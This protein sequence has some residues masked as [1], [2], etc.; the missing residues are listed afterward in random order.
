M[1]LEKIEIS[2]RGFLKFAGKGLA[3]GL[4]GGAVVGSQEGCVIRQGNEEVSFFGLPFVPAAS[5]EH[6]TYFEGTNR[7][8]ER[9]KTSMSTAFG[10][11]HIDISKFGGDNRFVGRYKIKFDRHAEGYNVL[12]EIYD[13][14]GKK[15]DTREGMDGIPGDVP[16]EVRGKM[17]Y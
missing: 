17:P 3:A 16:F 4:V 11:L 5:V 7:V 14:K 1:G 8:K 2:R 9:M 12:T 15:V 6:K 10:N 13:E